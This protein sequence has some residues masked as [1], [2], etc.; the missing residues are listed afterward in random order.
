[1]NMKKIVIYLLALTLTGCLW[2]C[3]DDKPSGHSI[4][5]TTVGPENEFEECINKAK[6]VM[7]ALKEAEGG[8]DND[9]TCR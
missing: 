9:I 6:A 5:D 8:I 1:M 7:N 3:D 2:S 4:F